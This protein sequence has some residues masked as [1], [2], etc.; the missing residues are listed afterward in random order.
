LCDQASKSKQATPLAT[1]HLSQMSAQTTLPATLFKINQAH[2][3]DSRWTAPVRP[4][5]FLPEAPS[6]HPGN[7]N[8]ADELSGLLTLQTMLGWLIMLQ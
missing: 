2:D 3:S 6:A 4:A 5:D 8:V 7:N 1:T